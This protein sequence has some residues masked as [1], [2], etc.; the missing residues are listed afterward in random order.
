[1]S[2]KEKKIKTLQLHPIFERSGLLTSAGYRLA[3]YV[4]VHSLKVSGYKKKYQVVQAQLLLKE[5]FWN[6]RS[7]STG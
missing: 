1:M 7:G 4:D 5:C 6:V 3:D 2:N